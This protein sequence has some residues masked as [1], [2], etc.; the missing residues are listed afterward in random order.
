VRL[1]ADLKGFYD[2]LAGLLPLGRNAQPAES[3]NVVTFLASA[4]AGYVNGS[5][6]QVDGGLAQV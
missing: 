5:D 6:I 1:S 2:H 4:Q 3:A